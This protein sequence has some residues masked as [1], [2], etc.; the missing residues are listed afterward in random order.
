MVKGHSVNRAEL[1]Q[2]IF[3]GR[4]VAMPGDHVEGREG[5]H[6]LKHAA[7]QLV[8]DHKVGLPVLVPCHRRLEIPRRCQA[9]GTCA[10]PQR[11]FRLKLHTL[12]EAVMLPM[13]R[14]IID[15]P[16]RATQFS[17]GPTSST[18]SGSGR[19]PI[20]SGRKQWCGCCSMLGTA[21][22]HSLADARCETFRPHMGTGL[23]GAARGEGCVGAHQRGRGQAG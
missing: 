3:V 14:S 8:H 2:I 20:L 7:A 10:S 1:C 21:A 12:I 16:L 6:R 9:I 22:C 23:L 13:Q 15:S 19:V 5:L 17:S 11:R 4:I 18:L